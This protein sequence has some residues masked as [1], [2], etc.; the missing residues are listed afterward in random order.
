MK[1]KEKK[2]KYI[3]YF[4]LLAIILDEWMK[5]NEIELRRRRDD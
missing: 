1:K 4:D 2:K 5:W 3:L